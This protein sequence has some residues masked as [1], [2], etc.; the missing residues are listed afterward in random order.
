MLFQNSNKNNN[1]ILVTPITTDEN[2][3]YNIIYLNENGVM[4]NVLVELSDLACENFNKFIDD[5]NSLYFANE[6]T[7]CLLNIIPD[8]KITKMK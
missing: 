2:P 5:K 1:I 7:K 4:N 8:K 6:Q 3:R